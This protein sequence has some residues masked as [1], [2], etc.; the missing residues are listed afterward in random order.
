MS[1]WQTNDNGSCQNPRQALPAAPSASTIAQTP[2]TTATSR[3]RRLD[4]FGSVALGSSLRP[5]RTETHIGPEIDI[6]LDRMLHPLVDQ[7][8]GFI[9]VI[10]RHLEDQLVVHGEQHVAVEVGSFPKGSIHRDHPDLEHVRG[11]SLDRCV[12]RLSTTEVAD[13]RIGG[14]ELRDVPTAS[15]ERLREPL[16]R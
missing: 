4:I 11:A 6:E 2:T 5:V 1:L 14:L 13:P 9:G 8:D 7:V 10:L 16:D 15:E 12:Q 3:C